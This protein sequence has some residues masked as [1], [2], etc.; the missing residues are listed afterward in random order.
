MSLTSVLL[1]CAEAE[2]SCDFKTEHES[3]PRIEWK[4]KDKEVSFVYFE[5]HFTG[6]C[7][8]IKRITDEIF[9]TAQLFLRKE[10][11]ITFN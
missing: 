10:K 11:M 5:G 9:L 4:K 6:V 7:Q 8:P 3:N 1:S 2:L